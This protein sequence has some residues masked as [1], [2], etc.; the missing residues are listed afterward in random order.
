M[1]F[2]SAFMAAKIQMQNV[3]MM[4]SYVYAMVIGLHARIENNS[5]TC[6]I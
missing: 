5:D 3:V 4:C 6:L 1:H 2:E